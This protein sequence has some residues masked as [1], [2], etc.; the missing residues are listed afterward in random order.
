[1]RNIFYTIIITL[2]AL[3]FVACNPQSEAPRLLA[4]AE[5]LVDINPDSAM[6]LIDSL[7][8]PEK[9]L[10]HEQY[11]RFLVTQV[12]AKYKTRRPVHEDTLI[13]RA[14]DYF[15]DRGKEPRMAALAW[16][17]SGCIHRERRVYEK[18]MEHYL[19]AGD[20]AAKAGDTGLQGLIQYNL[21]DLFAEQDLY[22]K[23]LQS[24]KTATQ[25]YNEQPEKEAYSLSAVGRM[26]LLDKNPDSAFFYFQ[27]GLNTAKHTDDKILQ[28]LLAQNIGVAYQ[29][30]G[31]YIEAEKYLLQSLQYNPDKKDQT[32][33]YLN[34]AKLYSQM[35]RQ[36][37]AA[38]YT[39][40]LQHNVDSSENNYLKASAYQ[41]LAEWEKARG[42]NDE[43]FGYQDKR[44]NSLNRIMDDR[45][46]QSVYEIEQKYNYEQQQNQ[47]DS[48]FRKAERFITILIVVILTGALTFTLYAFKQRNKQFQALQK[49]D[50]LRNMADEQKRLH[51]TSE[52]DA[53]RKI[54]RLMMEK[55]DTVKKVALLNSTIKENDSTK[56]VLEKLNKI[57]YGENFEEEW[58]ALLQVFNEINPDVSNVLRQQ[59][60]QLT[61]NEFRVFIL[62][63]AKFSPKEIAVVLNLTYDTVLTLRSSIRKKIKMSGS[64]SDDLLFF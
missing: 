10:S 59:Y 57:V 46:N 18:A 22:S 64:G 60:P 5:G 43:A 2:V 56:K 41:F 6:L 36:D 15:S 49:I 58:P 12:Q 35:E 38:F 53:K 48:R 4:V 3:V 34:F 32:R 24:Y 20:Y 8:Y 50:I 30:T 28:S 61:N 40:K 42:N 45:K 23:A 51:D 37:S 44:I 19:T 13:F 9:S 11:M 7:F 16:F 29:E 26:F 33:Y 52:L 63:Y 39:G 54:R 14:R 1:M 62:S 21:G 55:F 17:Y 47:F 27:K 31:Q 25:F